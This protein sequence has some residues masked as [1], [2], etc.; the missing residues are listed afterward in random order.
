MGKE[1]EAICFGPAQVN[2]TVAGGLWLQIEGSF[3][4]R[5]ASGEVVQRGN[6]FP[7][8]ETTLVRLVGRSITG[9]R[10]FDERHLLLEF[11][12]GDELFLSGDNGMYEA[13]RLFDGGREILV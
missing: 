6:G 9:C 10:V 2:L 12:E 7:L 5:S 4:H 1:I 11:S 13:Y 8:N 3:E